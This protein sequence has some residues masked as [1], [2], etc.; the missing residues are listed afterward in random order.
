MYNQTMAKG[1][2]IFVCSNCGEEYLKWQGKCD[3]CGQWNTLKEFQISK[4]M[5][6]GKFQM[7][8]GLPTEP[9]DLSKITIKNFQR[10][11]TKIG[12]FDRVLGGGIV[13][14]SVILLGGDPGIGKS[15]LALQAATKLEKVLYVSG[16]ESAGQI[17]MRFDRLGLKSNRIRVLAEIDLD[18]I[19]TATEKEK[20]QLL[21]VDSIQTI[22]SAGFPSTAG[23]IVQVRECSLRLQQLAKTTETSV[24]LIGHVTKEGSVAGPRTLEHLVDVVLY[25][26]GERFHH[27]R[28]L[29]SAKNRFGATDEIGI[30]EMSEQGLKEVKNPSKLFLEERLKNVPGTVVT[31]TVEGTRSFLVEVQALTSTTAFGFPQR[32]SSGFDLNRLQLLIAVL[33][34]R[35]NLNLASQDVFINIV[36]GVTIK[37]PAVDLAVAMAIAGSLKNK[38]VDP[39]LCI[40]GELGL[41]G[42]VRRVTYEQK[43]ISEAKRL[44]F[45][46]FIQTKTIG[47]LAR[48]YF[49]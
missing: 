39:K 34:K 32:R 8:D 21:I 35:A 28:I 31:A 40:F 14:G 23:S 4:Y 46:K 42:E 5:P 49:V 18:S 45:T 25:L 27:N 20:P 24:I 37:E 16:E 33:Q 29:R 19:I 43:R 6:K 7:K 12:E 26:E 10:I 15:T 36:G 47:E 2:I 41:S 9:I 1:E 48:I 44:G 38:T 22:Y 13:P 3:N 30:F 11:S 17:K